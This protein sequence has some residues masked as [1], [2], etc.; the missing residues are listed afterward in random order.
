V[1]D[2]GDTERSKLFERFGRSFEAGAQIY[3]EGDE[4]VCCYL[5]QEGRV[6]LVKRIRSSDRS[7]TVLRPGDLFG[8]DAL[9]TGTAR[10]ASAVALTDVSVL[11][12][13]RATFGVL[14]SSNPDVALRL[15]EQVVRRLRH[16][17]EQL[18]NAMLR[19]QPSRVV[20]TLIHLSAG[21]ERSA[22][23][24][25][26]TISPLELSSRV[27]LDVDAVKR[28]VQ[29]LRDGGYLRIHDEKII[30][31]DLAALRQLYELLGMK[32]E[33]RGGLV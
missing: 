24:H 2:L 14:L 32:E 12:L 33:V 3:A 23:G 7:L 22:E 28:A 26:L 18:E 1:E 6:R 16:A 21:T 13:D 25:V 11:A 30:L 8:E 31:P 5:I 27:G 20:N 10:G 9:V 29:Q 19:D 15:V 17:E 4:A